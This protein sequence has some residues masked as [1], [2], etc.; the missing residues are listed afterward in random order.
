MKNTLLIFISGLIVGGSVMYFFIQPIPQSYEIT[1]LK[2]FSDKQ[3]S[4]SEE[5]VLYTNEQ[6]GFSFSYPKGLVYKEFDEGAGAQTIVFQK[7]NDIKT[8]FQIYVTPYAEKTITGER[9]LYDASGAVSDL[10]EEYLRDDFIVATFESDAPI[11][12]KTREIWFLHGGYLFEVT[13]YAELDEWLRGIV[14]TVKF[15]P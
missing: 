11:F 12:G 15:T 14:K 9:I 7:P 8:G 6:Y 10:K 4:V 13:T 5:S 2:T 1:R 3:G